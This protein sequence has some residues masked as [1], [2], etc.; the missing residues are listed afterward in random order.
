MAD[1]NISKFTTQV[2]RVGSTPSSPGFAVDEGQ[3]P[4]DP[5]GNPQTHLP[6]TIAAAADALSITDAQVL[7]G[8][9]TTA[10]YIRGNGSLATF[11]SLTGFVPY[12]GATAD[13]NLGTHDLT[14]ERGTFQNN[15]SSD[16]LTVNHTSGSG[17]GIIVTKGGNN[18]AL[19]VSKTSGS[20]NAM[21]VIGGRTSLVDLALSSVTNTA[22]D[23]LTLSGGVVHKRTAAEV[24]TDIGAGTVTSVAA[25][26]LGTSGTD[27]SSTVANGTTTPVITLNVPT[28]S[29]SNRGALS[30]ADWTTFNNKQNALTNPVTGTGSAGQV[31]YFTGTSAIS[32]ESNLFWDGT[33]DRLGI[34]T[35]SPTNPLHVETTGADL[36]IQIYR[37]VNSD[38]GSAPL[39]LSHKSTAGI[40]NTVNI[41]AIGSGSMVFRTGATGLAAFGTTR[42][43]L[44][45]NGRLL[46]G[47]PP[48]TESTFQL[49][50]NGTG[51]FSGELLVSRPAMTTQSSY[52]Y[53]NIRVNSGFGS[54]YTDARIQSLLAGYDGVI[55]GTDIGYSYDGGGVGNTGYSLRFST[56]ED[57]TGNPI[58]RLRINSTGAATFS[59]SV[60]ASSF[61]R[62]GGTS[63]EF[64]KADGSVDSTTYVP[65]GRTITI[66]GTT[67]DLSANRTFNVGTVT[68]VTAS[69]PLA[70]SGGATPNITIQQA[71]GSQ[72]GFLSSTD[73]TTFNNKQNALT[74][75]VTG[76]GSAGQVAYW[77]SGS[78]ITG[79]SNLFWDATNDRLGIGTN[80][81]AY[82]LDIVGTQKIGGVTLPFLDFKT[83][84]TTG[85]GFQFKQISYSD[86]TNAE[87]WNIGFNYPYLQFLVGGTRVAS[88]TPNG[89]VLINTITD[90]GFKLDVNGTG[91]F[92]QDLSAVFNSNS[93]TP[94]IRFDQSS[95][96]KFFIGERS[97]VSGSGGTG[98]DF[99]TSSG[100]DIRFFTGGSSTTK[101]CV[102]TSG[103]IGI[104]TTN[105]TNPL[106]VETTGAD[107]GIQIYRNVS[108][109][110]GSAPLF[111]SHKSTAGVI[112]TVSVEALGNGAMVFRTGAT[113]L[114]AFGSD[115]MHITSGG[116]VLIGT[117]DDNS[118]KLRVN[119]SVFINANTVIDSKTTT[120][121]G[122]T[123]VPIAN[124]SGSE[125]SFYLITA[126]SGANYYRCSVMQVQNT[127]I[128]SNEIT[129]GTF[130]SNGLNI[131]SGILNMQILTGTWTVKCTQ[132]R[133][134]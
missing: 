46:I 95:S 132:I 65:V 34:G 118:N 12:T 130:S 45:A 18:E 98:Y 129:I 39:F 125:G 117:A 6:V 133:T 59:S 90:S 107:L 134:V 96:A 114:A 74:N 94:Y 105:P 122:F 87:L 42:M 68:S 99:Y 131:V 78:A 115:R 66:N 82:N 25:L 21:T 108:S 15:G 63:S 48:P 20:G 77:S 60:T 55:Y 113:G 41:E 100:N 70:S 3:D 7:S 51:R 4:V 56:N 9:G 111:L 8:A 126:V 24:R 109:D 50:V 116:N 80:I 13:V 81:P 69:S 57:L 71:S 5:S 106:H 40:I 16:T 36:G 124:L 76:T 23:F 128:R 119:G 26:T 102:A 28:A 53:Q 30:S 72:S 92:T 121:V 62:V 79:E 112:N 86:A 85:A 22:G 14:A 93:N 35:A 58:E 37:N 83:N 101:L 32:S 75:P 44:T 110:G 89:N 61:I 2:L 91:R 10:Q 1:I 123:P 64:L 127:I 38:L 54:G 97:I 31:A 17:Y 120:G 47:T 33:N 84:A 104:G 88:F 73:W 52:D 29:A 27:L 11:P 67:Q 103:S 19:Y 49:D 43:Q